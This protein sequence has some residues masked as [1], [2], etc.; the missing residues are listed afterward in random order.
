M[1]DEADE[2]RGKHPDKALTA[3]RVRALKDPGRYAD[4]NGLH[5][6]VDSSGAK[7]WILRT[8]IQGRRS[9]IG[10]GGVSLV[11]LAEAR[12]EAAALRKIARAG[13]DPLAERRK[14][15]A[16]VPTFE[17]AACRVHGEQSS[18]WKNPKHQ[19]QWINTL[20]QYVF[21]ELGSRR[22]DQIDTPDVHRV[23]APIWLA[24]PESARRVRQRIGTVLD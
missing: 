19:A 8:V 1:W 9:D 20:A 17:Q 14:A 16:I 11:S 18:G 13:G 24:K 7:R 12:K 21:P 23:L 3:A 2:A 4:G 10:L 15:R 5:L 6:V 22:V